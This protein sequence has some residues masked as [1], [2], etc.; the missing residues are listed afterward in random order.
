MTEMESEEDPSELIYDLP[1]CFYD[2]MG[3][4]DGY[5]IRCGV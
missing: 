2:D 3:R 1:K 4:I 5:D